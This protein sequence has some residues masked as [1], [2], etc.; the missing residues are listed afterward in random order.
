ML[1]VLIIDPDPATRDELRIVTQ[2]CGRTVE[3]CASARSGL[4]VIH[5][6]QPRVLV[7]ELILPDVDG[8]S[9]CQRL[10][11][12]ARYDD[13]KIL[14]I[15]S[16]SWGTVDLASLLK[17]RFSAKYLAKG[18]LYSDYIRTLDKLLGG[19]VSEPP[20]EAG[21][22]LG[23]HEQAAVRTMTEE[24]EAVIA[25]RSW[26][27]RASVRF[28]VEFEV[29]FST[30]KQLATE[31]TKN[32]SRGGLFIVT[33]DPP[34]M[35][36]MVDITLRLPHI[37]R[38]LNVRG[39]VV[40]RVLEAKPNS[41]TGFGLQFEDLSKELKEMLGNLA[42]RLSALEG[43]KAPAPAAQ[44]VVTVG[45]PAG[46]LMVRSSGLGRKNVRLIELPGIDDALDFS[47]DDPS[48]GL[49]VAQSAL[50]KDVRASLARVR[51]VFP[52]SP[53]VLVGAT[54]PSLEACAL[55]KRIVPPDA[56]IE[57]TIDIIEEALG[58]VRRREARIPCD[59]PAT[60]TLLGGERTARL[61]DLS[62]SGAL[63]K[64]EGAVPSASLLR[65][66]FDLHKIGPIDVRA[67]VVR[68]FTSEQK[69][70]IGVGFYDVD[71]EMRDK[72]RRF[73]QSNVSFREYFDWVKK[74]R[75]G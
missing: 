17:R 51:D 53:C 66:H 14:C 7:V 63:L 10:R 20:L 72:L 50:G 15:S 58:L 23:G 54:D 73:A 42:T 31:F 39:R 65:M 11:D 9:F 38:D 49:V 33:K 67:L 46:F 32:I 5:A 44:W 47:G 13:L 61:V 45:L 26:H 70:F 75:F 56:S 68:Q 27:P 1:D 55:C 2:A 59:A 69:N 18:S 35:D 74:R 19:S 28:E 48:I 29:T 4:E 24:F 41:P 36:A 40:H 57:Q 8:F 64:T 71:D 60:V 16:L 30:G 37:K 43:S 25:A 21:S 62:V 3:V 6:W 22:V 52:R 34:P 12:D